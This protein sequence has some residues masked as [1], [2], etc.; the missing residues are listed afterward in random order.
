M[1]RSMEIFEGQPYVQYL[2]EDLVLII[3]LN[4]LHESP[5][6]TP[7]AE[8]GHSRIPQ[9]QLTSRAEKASSSTISGNSKNKKLEVQ[10][11]NAQ[12]TT[13]MEVNHR[14]KGTTPK[15][16]RPTSKTTPSTPKRAPVACDTCR[17]RKKR[18]VHNSEASSP[19]KPDAMATTAAMTDRISVIDPSLENPAPRVD[20]PASLANAKPTA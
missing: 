16:P 1:I 4:K 14:P 6:A 9:H 20:T 18:C 8:G 11:R 10:L 12:G 2:H 13:A 17:R 3:L 19:E 7:K 15:R 5:K